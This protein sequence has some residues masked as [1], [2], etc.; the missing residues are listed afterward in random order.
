MCHSSRRRCEPIPLWADTKK[1]P[2][3]DGKR[4]QLDEYIPELEE[5]ELEQVLSMLRGL[6][7]NASIPVVRFVWRMSTMTSPTR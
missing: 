2:V 5:D 4:L 6:R 1:T 7:L 3:S